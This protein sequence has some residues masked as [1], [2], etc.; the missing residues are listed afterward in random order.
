MSSI[1]HIP[2]PAEL[3]AHTEFLRRL[4]RRLVGDE[5]RAEDLAQEALAQEALVAR[6]AVMRALM[7]GPPT[8][9][10]SDCRRAIDRRR[11]SSA[12]GRRRRSRS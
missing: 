10:G 6:L 8:R 1:E 12:G 7:S 4:A 5:H 2:E 9:A 11:S 3:A